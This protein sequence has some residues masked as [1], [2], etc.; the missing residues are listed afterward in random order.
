MVTQSAPAKERLLHEATRLV[1]EKGFGATSIYDLL[2]A[3]GLKK[4]S[5]YFHFASKHEL[6][7][8]VLERA[9]VEFA[10]FRRAALSGDTPEA[11]LHH[12]FDAVL[13]ANRQCGFVGGCLWGNTALEMSDTDEEYAKFV[14][15][16]FD[17]WTS[18]IEAVIVAGQTEGQ[19]RA[20]V[21]ACQL[22]GHVVAAIEGGVM[23]S[24]LRKAEGPLKSVLDSLE[25]LLK[26]LSGTTRMGEGASR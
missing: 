14:A 4:G 6:G 23:Q 7:L 9:R 22:A 16:V 10:K 26:P 18:Q 24:R 2:A 11:R 13:S 15:E 21:P 5:L 1:H 25:A 20:D 17:E 8:S 12:F 3:V 19:F